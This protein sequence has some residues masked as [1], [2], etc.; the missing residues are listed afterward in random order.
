MQALALFLAI[1]AIGLLPF[2]EIVLL[3]CKNGQV[4]AF[5]RA[6]QTSGGTPQ[7]FQ[8]APAAE[9]CGTMMLTHFGKSMSVALRATCC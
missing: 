8:G 2:P 4:A 5:A 1:P 9:Q 3:K 7:F 6:P